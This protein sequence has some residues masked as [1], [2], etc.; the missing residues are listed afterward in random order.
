MIYQVIGL[1]FSYNLIGVWTK[2]LKKSNNVRAIQF[3]RINVS[4]RSSFLVHCAKKCFHGEWMK[5]LKVLVIFLLRG[6]TFALTQKDDFWWHL[7][8]KKIE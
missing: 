2:L 7:Y 4:C 6:I 8:F 1:T 5:I 3:K